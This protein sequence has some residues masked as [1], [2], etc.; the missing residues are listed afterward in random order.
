[1][2]AFNALEVVIGTLY[3]TMK[4]PLE[5]GQVRVIKGDEGI[6]MKCYKDSLKLK[7]KIQHDHPIIENT[8]KVNL[9]DLDPREDPAD[10]SLTPIRELKKV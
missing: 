4:C 9:A 2:L 1:M 5:G 7:N 3:L 8:L 6:A 10:D